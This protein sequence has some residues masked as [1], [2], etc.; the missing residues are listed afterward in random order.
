M[1]G[2]HGTYPVHLDTLSQS[3]TCILRLRQSRC[4]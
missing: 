4:L 2:V 1:T 3:A